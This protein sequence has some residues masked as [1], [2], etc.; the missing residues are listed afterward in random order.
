MPEP[1][2][3]VKDLLEV[4]GE[5]IGVV[6]ENDV[7][8]SNRIVVNLDD[9]LLPLPGKDIKS[10][11]VAQTA[12][13]LPRKQ[14]VEGST[15]SASSTGL[16]VDQQIA[17]RNI[18]SYRVKEEDSRNALTT[19][20]TKFQ[21]EKK[22]WEDK[23]AAHNRRVETLKEDIRVNETS[24]LMEEGRLRNLILNGVLVNGSVGSHVEEP[25]IEEKEQEE[26]VEIGRAD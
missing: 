3:E 26:V 7:T 23:Q 18:V 4:I 21:T 6:T 15:P 12:E 13:R 8:R 2:N 25:K 5:V 11:G 10:A 20:N 14:E 16:T 1:S 22:A 19:E 24:A 9:I 17:F